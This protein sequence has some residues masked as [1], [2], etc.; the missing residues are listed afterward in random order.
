MTE[1][2]KKTQQNKK[3]PAKTPLSKRI[4][5]L[6]CVFLLV[7][8]YITTLLVAIFDRS[9]SGR[10]FLLCVIATIFIPILCWI[11][12]WLYGVIT[13]RHTIASFDI[14]RDDAKETAE[15]SEDSGNESI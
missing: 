11:Y 14:R 4:A 1:N 7:A 12:F 2:S 5:A 8:L 15:S 9:S 3:E 13:Q 6:V 10:W